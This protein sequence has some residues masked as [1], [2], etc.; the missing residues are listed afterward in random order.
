MA[1]PRQLRNSIFN[2][3]LGSALAA[4]AVAVLMVVVASQPAQAQTYKV[5][6]NFTGGGDG[7]QP[8][9][10]V[11]LDKAGNLYGTTFRGGAT[12]NGAVFQLKLKNSN[13]VFNPLY[14]F[15]G[16]ATGRVQPAE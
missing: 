9:A 1:N 6:Y 11:T 15:S 4:L 3:S 5:I 16:A 10:G 7:A 2:L 12:D 13:F 14:S 8:Y